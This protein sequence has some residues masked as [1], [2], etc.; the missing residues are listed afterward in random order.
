LSDAQVSNA[1]KKSFVLLDYLRASPDWQ[2]VY[3]D[4]VAEIFVKN[5]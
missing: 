5:K 1:T 3:R 4:D 2:S